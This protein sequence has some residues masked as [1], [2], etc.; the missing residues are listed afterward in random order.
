[1][2]QTVNLFDGEIKYDGNVI[3]SLLELNLITNI[4]DGKIPLNIDKF[5]KVDMIC[6]FGKFI[7]NDDNNFNGKDIFITQNNQNAAYFDIAYLKGKNINSPKLVY[8]QVKKSLSSNKINIQEAKQIFEKKKKIFQHYLIL[9][10]K[11]LI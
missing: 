3:G 10:Q 8:I 7:E 6:E 9:Y 2:K 1:M 4:K 11:K 5:C